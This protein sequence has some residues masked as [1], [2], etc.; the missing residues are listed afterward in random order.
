M[1]ST[2]TH[3]PLFIL[4]CS[5]EHEKLQM[6]AKI[7]SLVAVSNRPVEVLV[8]MNAIL[9]FAKDTPEEQRYTGG[10]FSKSLHDKHV[11]T[12]AQL[13]R[14][15]KEFGDLKVWAC[16]MAL[17]VHGWDMQH[18]IADLFDGSL[19]LTRFMSDAEKGQFITI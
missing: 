12:A 19:G 10:A 17:D 6:A 13:F 2:P 1:A 8:S 4:L 5:G 3:T 14:Q 7:A 11:P 15:G 9:A 18:L 16:A